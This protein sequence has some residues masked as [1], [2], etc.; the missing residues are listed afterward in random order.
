MAVNAADGTD[1]LLGIDNVDSSDDP[2]FINNTSLEMEVTLEESDTEITFDGNSSP[3]SFPLPPTEIR[4]V[5]IEATDDSENAFVDI[6]ADLSENGTSRGQITLQRDFSVSPAESIEFTGEARS[7]GGSGTYRFTLRNVGNVDITFTGVRIDQ[8]TAESPT[9]SAGLELNNQTV[10]END[11][12]IGEDGPLVSFDGVTIEAGQDN[13]EGR[14][15]Q[16]RPGGG[17]GNSPASMDG[18][19]LRVTFQFEASG[20]TFTSTTDLCIDGCDLD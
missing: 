6:T 4:S 9:R 13:F 17:P 15:G 8:T 10:V 11:L 18:E 5:E 16:F 14:F 12:H 2:V 19:D 3:F 20:E 7:P 1:A